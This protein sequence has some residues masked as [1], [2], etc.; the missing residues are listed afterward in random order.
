M[1]PAPHDPI[2][3]ACLEEILGGQSP[4]DLSASILEAVAESGSQPVVTP[5]SAGTAET[6]G[7][8]LLQTAVESASCS[9]TTQKITRP[10]ASGRRTWSQAAIITSVLTIG[11]CLGLIA[12]KFLPPTNP[13]SDAPVAKNTK[14]SSTQDPTGKAPGTQNSQESPKPPT[15]ANKTPSQPQESTPSTPFDNEAGP[16]R[17]PEVASSSDNSSATRIE[18]F[19]DKAII[20]FVNHELSTSWKAASLSPSPTATDAEWCR[21]VYLRLLGRIPTKQE[22]DAFASSK[23]SVDKRTALVEKLLNDKQYVEEYARHWTTIWTNLLIG[24]RGGIG[25]GDLANREGLQKYLGDVFQQNRPYDQMAYELISATGSNTPG[26]E[27]YNGA[28]NFMLASMNDQ[29]T[30]ATARTSRIFLGKQLQC[31]QCH[32]HPTN[33]WAQQN[34]WEMNAFFRQLHVVKDKQ[35]N[36]NRLVNQDFV[37]KQ[38]NPND[39]EIY[40]GQPDGSMSVAYPRFLGGKPLEHN[41]QVAQFD[42]RTE[43]AKLVRQSDD[44]S[45]ALVNRIWAHFL[46]YGF[47]RPIDDMGHHNPASHPKLLD[48][49]TQQFSAHGYDMKD[50]FR[51]IALSDA[52]ALSSRLSSTNS[53]DTPEL[54]EIPYFSRY[55]MRPMQPEEVYQSLLM[56]AG[57]NQ[58]TG[59][60]LE[61]EQARRDWLGQFAQ[62]METD[63]GDESN[64]FSGNIHQSL[65][66]MNGPLMKQATSANAR[67]VLAKVME[68]KMETRQK[69]EHLFLASVARK[70]TK[71]E[72]K[73]VQQ[74]LA[75]TTP[76]QMLQDIWWALLNSNEFILDH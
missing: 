21:R 60:P 16:V 43:L 66:M 22:L 23:P 49:L 32:K 35:S 50:L 41:G 11:A 45:R 55:Y 24:R 13:E 48:H 30:L 72:L 29:A 31:V 33:N 26:T 52:F 53:L 8:S 71:R 74:M 12:I 37:G 18:P 73:L 59:S 76:Q 51:W 69:V 75:K 44:L 58:P 54:G 10:A 34:F 36:V 7:S 17:P 68:S 57:R 40:Y 1:K 20:K 39:A 14:K 65:V 9:D 27:D 6:A 4:P 62:K 5:P 42:R 15:I 63:E 47:T 56:V 70:P 38:G 46:G 61:M 67:S 64:L 25:K 19:E 28:V 2:L 3:D